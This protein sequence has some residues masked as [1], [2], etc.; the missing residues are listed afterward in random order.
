MNGSRFS[1]KNKVDGEYSA[2][3]GGFEARDH[4]KASR[5]AALHRT[6]SDSKC[7]QWSWLIL[8]SHDRESP[9]REAKASL[10]RPG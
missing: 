10:S 3:L 4:G 8:L 2:Y 1:H 6:R 7:K 9:D 5:A